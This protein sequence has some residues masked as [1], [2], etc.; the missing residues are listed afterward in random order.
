[1]VTSIKYNNFSYTIVFNLEST[2]AIILL[3][4]V[5]LFTIIQS[6]FG[7]GRLVFGTPTMLLIGFSFIETLSYLL[8]A[9]IVVSFL[10]VYK[11]W[12]QIKLYRINV[13]F[14]ILPMVVIGLLFVIYYFNFNLY[15]IIGLTLLLTSLTRFS[16][17]LNKSL[18]FYFSNNYKLGFILTGIIHGLT[19]LGG[20]PL[21][22]LTNGL[23]KTKKEIQPNIAY[24]Y[25]FMAI[26]QIAI[27]IVT[28][29]LVFSSD[30]LIIP[31]V[32]GVIYLCLG[33]FIFE[34]TNEKFYYNLMTFFLMAYGLILLS[35]TLFF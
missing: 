8:P 2:D 29:T 19:N 13:I 34:F 7:V 11:N 15:L 28:D 20:A 3:L 12:N 17:T 25:L 6:V 14:Y 9:S 24:A 30:F 35:K 18:E 21:V 27:L 31:I 22:I 10:Q 4:I 26:I 5:C 32:A 23:Y 33:N 1:M 16:Q